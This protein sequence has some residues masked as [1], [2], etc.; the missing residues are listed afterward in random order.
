MTTRIGSLA[1]G[2]LL[3]LAVACGGSHTSKSTTTD[4]ET[5]AP[6]NNTKPTNT[7]VTA[8]SPANTPTSASAAS[9]TF[10]MCGKQECA[11]SLFGLTVKSWCATCNTD[12]RFHDAANQATMDYGETVT[13]E[14]PANFSYNNDGRIYVL[15]YT[16]DTHGKRVTGEVESGNTL[17]LPDVE[18]GMFYLNRLPAGTPAGT[19]GKTQKDSQPLPPIKGGSGQVLHPIFNS[20]GTV[21]ANGHKYA[22]GDYFCQTMSAVIGGPSDSWK[23]ARDQFGFL[24]QGCK[25]S[26]KSNEFLNLPADTVTHAPSITVV[27][28]AFKM[29]FAEATVYFDTWL[30][31]Y[32]GEWTCGT[33]GRT[34][35]P[36]KAT[37]IAAG[38]SLWGI[39]CLKNG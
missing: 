35:N 20:D 7:K 24:T 23:Q 12:S 37:W 15:S 8:N 39:P 16:V 27:G 19:V 31:A 3:L 29:N 26:S 21:D 30:N 6:I 1:L 33:V 11:P 38:E 28:P 17:S 2:A 32:H 18:W 5:S 10:P 34:D 13:L 9:A 14:I 4:N 25:L 36:S 22:N